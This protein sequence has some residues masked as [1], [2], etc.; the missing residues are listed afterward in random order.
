MA[1][2]STTTTATGTDAAGGGT[3]TIPEQQPERKFTQA[4]V[5]RFIGERLTRERA[6]YADY[7]QLKKDAAAWKKTQ[8]A[9]LSEVDKLK[10]KLAETETARAQAESLAQERLIKVAFVAAASAA[11]AKHVG[12][13]YRLAD[14]ANIEIQEDGSVKG[15]VE[16]VAK[17][18]KDGRLPVKGAVAPNLDGG[19]GGGKRPGEVSIEFNEE[20]ERSQAVRLGVN[21]DEFV[22][23]KKAALMAAKK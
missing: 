21:P 18:V 7:D 23:N 13:A 1:E 5:D 2:Q 14:I 12:D 10:A 17:M 15:V 4:D 19:N 11:D 8:E 6:Q 9:Q 16:E 20:A 3:Q 22:K